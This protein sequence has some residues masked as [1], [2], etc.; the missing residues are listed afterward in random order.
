MRD[1][2]N[3][4]TGDKA[5]IANR[6]G[7]VLHAAQQFFARR[8]ASKPNRRA[9][10]AL[11]REAPQARAELSWVTSLLQEAL[12]V[13]QAET[14]ARRLHAAPVNSLGLS[15]IRPRPIEAR[16]RHTCNV[17]QL[18]K[19]C[20]ASFASAQLDDPLGD[21]AADPGDRG[22]L[23]GAGAI[24][25]DARTRR[26]PRVPPT[27]SWGRVRA[28][29]LAGCRHVNLVTVRSPRRQIDAARIGRRAEAPR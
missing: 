28:S 12:R 10:R 3:T 29:S 5:G 17:E 7:D 13:A 25:V 23:S 1:Q 9:R 15:Q 20:K 14:N 24:D 22:Q 21:R 18:V 16:L 2:C 26:R 19:R 6:A 8:L 27:A 11:R 4:I